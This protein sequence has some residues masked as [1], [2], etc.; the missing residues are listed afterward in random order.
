MK[1]H[2]FWYIDRPK[3]IEFEM[4]RFYYRYFLH[5][6]V[7]TISVQYKEANV[8]VTDNCIKFRPLWRMWQWTNHTAP[9]WAKLKR[10]RIF[11]TRSWYC[12]VSFIMVLV[13]FN[14]KAPNIFSF[15]SYLLQL[16]I[17]MRVMEP[18]RRIWCLSKKEMN[19]CYLKEILVMDGLDVVMLKQ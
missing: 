7:I 16:D 13:L 8:I 17:P 6:I 5:T 9:N 10:A 14:F 1:D 11:T 15:N 2:I 4:I 12:I 19:W 18:M 3:S